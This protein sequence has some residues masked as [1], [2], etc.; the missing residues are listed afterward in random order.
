[1]NSSAQDKAAKDREAAIAKER[2]RVEA[3]RKAEADAQAK[4]EADAKLRAK[5]RGEISEDIQE[6]T[7]T[8]L[9]L[10]PIVDAIMDGKVRH[11]RV[12][13]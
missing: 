10:E 9:N 6:I 7:G 13:F 11:V 2:A 3:Q 8:F 5:I 1:M 12:T 4:R